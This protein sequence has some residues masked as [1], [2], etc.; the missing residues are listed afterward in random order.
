VE[1]Q[2]AGQRMRMKSILVRLKN[3]MA[4]LPVRLA[5]W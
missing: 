5:G 2:M 3:S 1:S 4:R